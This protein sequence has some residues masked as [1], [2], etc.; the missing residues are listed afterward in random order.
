MKLTVLHCDRDSFWIVRGLLLCG[1][2][3]TVRGMISNMA[4]LIDRYACT[5][6]S[7]VVVTIFSILLFMFTAQFSTLPLWN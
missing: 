1:M 2:N 6:Y 3:T 4:F 5:I 7:N